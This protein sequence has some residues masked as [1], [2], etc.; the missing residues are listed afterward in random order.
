LMIN[1]NHEKQ[2]FLFLLFLPG[3]NSSRGWQYNFLSDI[4]LFY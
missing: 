3:S 4:E 1:Y 2:F